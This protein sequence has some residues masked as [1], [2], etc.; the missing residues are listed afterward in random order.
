MMASLR[1]RLKK[2]ELEYQAA[3][4]LAAERGLDP[5]EARRRVRRTADAPCAGCGGNDSLITD[6]IQKG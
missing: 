4:R 5:A 1:D 6:H 2:A 3:Q